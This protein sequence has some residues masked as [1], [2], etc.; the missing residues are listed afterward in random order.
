MRAR[1]APAILLLALLPS[2]VLTAAQDAPAPK[3]RAQML[4]ATRDLPDP[5]FHDSVVLMLP[6]KEGPLLVGL[7]INKPSKIKIRD[8]FPDSP[9]LQQSDAVAY[10][11]GPVDAAVVARSAVFRSKTP[12][13]GATLVF[14]DVYVTFD[15]G[16]ILALAENAPQA[17]TVRIF[18]GRAQWAQQQFDNE[19]AHGAWHILPATPDSVFSSLPEFLWRSLIDRAEP[20]PV[21]Q[22]APPRRPPSSVIP[23]RSA[24]FAD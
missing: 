3:P 13:K 9:G 2:F 16:E 5:L 17:S 19:V 4:V 14:A 18:L 10:F 8:V 22:S 12:P 15:P 1:L 6:V 21:A 23:S 11:G 24:F 20:R 7:I